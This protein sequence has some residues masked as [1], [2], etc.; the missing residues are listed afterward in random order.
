MI[1]K[2]L[3]FNIPVPRNPIRKLFF[4]IVQNNYFDYGITG[5]IILNTITM[6]IKFHRMPKEMDF[7]LEITNYIFA[8][9]FLLEAVFKILGQGR[10]Y[11]Y[12]AWNK[13]DLGIVIAT[14]LGIGLQFF[15]IGFDFST[16]ATVVRAFRIMRIFKLV[17]VS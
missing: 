15:N 17:R 10:M 5:C 7:T 3:K 6:S 14:T 4:I 8:F 16:T 12:S 9:I 2:S 13:F 11:F 1:R